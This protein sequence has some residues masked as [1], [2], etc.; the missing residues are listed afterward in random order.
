MP[1]L[2]TQAG[3]LLVLGKQAVLVVGPC[4]SLGNHGRTRVA[5]A[6]TISYRVDKY[7]VQEFKWFKYVGTVASVALMP[8]A[9]VNGI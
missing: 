7:C 3:I 8:W 2:L 5:L 4:I 6:L 1:A 9:P